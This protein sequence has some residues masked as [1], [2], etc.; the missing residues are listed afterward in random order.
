MERDIRVSRYGRSQF[1]AFKNWGDTYFKGEWRFYQDFIQFDKT[2]LQRT[3]QVS[4][5]G[6]RFLSGFPLEFRWWVD[7]V[8]YLRRQA[9][10]GTGG[11]TGQCGDGLRLDLRPEL[12]LPFR[13]ASYLFGSLSVAPRETVYHLYSP[14]N[15]SDRNISRELVEIR[16]NVGTYL[17][18]VFSWGTPGTGGIR[19][20]IEP[21]LSYFFVPGVNQNNIPIMDGVDRVRR[22]N[23]LTLAVANRLWR[24]SGSVS[25]MLPM[26]E[27]SH[28]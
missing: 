3:P 26:L 11:V 19:H 24:R 25:P 27:K 16:G 20:V 8:N 7:G 14:V 6:R 13:V 10:P 15:P 21:E 28:C 22:R 1:G 23:V 4:F 12:V 2:T 18:R 5:W 9:C 17:S